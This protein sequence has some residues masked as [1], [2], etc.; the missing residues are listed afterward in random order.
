[1]SGFQVGSKAGKKRPAAS[2]TAGGANKK[3]NQEGQR[4]Y[5][6]LAKD[7]EDILSIAEDLQLEEEHV[8]AIFSKGN[9]YKTLAR[10]K[11]GTKSF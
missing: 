6:T 5:P 10:R 9:L 2:A 8:N 7:T 3:T 4:P 1:M 11:I